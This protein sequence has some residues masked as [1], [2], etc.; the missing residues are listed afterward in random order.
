MTIQSFAEKYR[1]RVKE[2]ECGEPVISGRFSKHHLN[3]YPTHNAVLYVDGNLLCMLLI[4]APSREENTWRKI[5]GKLWSGDRSPNRVGNKVQDVKIT[6]IPESGYRMA[7]KLA[8]VRPIQKRSPERLAQGAKAL[9]G[10]REASSK[11][12]T[13][14]PTASQKRTKRGAPVSDRGLFDD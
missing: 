10:H 4:D 14:E 13:G 7:M 5:G 2:D 1:L 8:G 12:N 11:R 9:A 3:L 6:G